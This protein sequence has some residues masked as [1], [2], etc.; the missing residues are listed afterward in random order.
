MENNYNWEEILRNCV[1]DNTIKALYLEHIPK[2][3]DC[4]DWKNAIFL[5]RVRH[6]FKLTEVDGGLVKSNGKLY[7]INAKQIIALARVCKWNTGN[8][9]NVKE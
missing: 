2:L 5:G 3:V 7:F 8:I 6:K 4:N 9:I 1:T